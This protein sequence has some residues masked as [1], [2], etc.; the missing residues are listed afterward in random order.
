M[1]SATDYE[2]FYSLIVKSVTE[3]QYLIE[4]NE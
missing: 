2:F 3:Q 4:Y 1:L